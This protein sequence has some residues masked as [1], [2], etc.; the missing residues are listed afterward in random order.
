MILRKISQN[1][2]SRIFN[3][4]SL[5]RLSGELKR[6]YLVIPAECRI[7]DLA[8]NVLLPSRQFREII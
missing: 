6:E 4:L 8:L 2:C 1:Q 5:L 3:V 7:S